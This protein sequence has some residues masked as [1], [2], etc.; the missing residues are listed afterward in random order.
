MLFES[1]KGKLPETGKAGRINLI[2][3]KFLSLII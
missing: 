1:G 2:A 3:K